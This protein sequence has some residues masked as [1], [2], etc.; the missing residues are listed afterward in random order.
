MTINY[1]AAHI[2]RIAFPFDALFR[3][4]FESAAAPEFA[5]E[6]GQA[7]ANIL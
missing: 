2:V 7:E 6:V 1:A 3:L 5:H 4:V